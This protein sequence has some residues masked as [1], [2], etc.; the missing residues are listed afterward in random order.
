MLIASCDG[1]E[2]GD[3]DG[4]GDGEQNSDSDSDGDYHSGMRCKCTAR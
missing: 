1:H 3:G 2:A 4:D